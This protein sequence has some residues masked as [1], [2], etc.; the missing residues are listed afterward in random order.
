MG[1]TKKMLKVELKVELKWEMERKQKMSIR[2]Q[3]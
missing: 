2:V 1:K 3:Q